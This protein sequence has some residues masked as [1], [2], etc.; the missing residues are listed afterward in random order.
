MEPLL[1]AFPVAEGARRDFDVIVLLGK[2][3]KGSEFRPA[4][5][6]SEAIMKLVPGLSCDIHFLL[7]RAKTVEQDL[8]KIRD[9][10]IN[11]TINLYR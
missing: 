10:Q 5:S 11:S 9:G 7:K 6:I 2:I 4:A 8:R 1:M 3:L